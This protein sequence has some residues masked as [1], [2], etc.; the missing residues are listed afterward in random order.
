MKKCITLA[1]A[2]MMMVSAA[3]CGGSKNDGSAGYDVTSATALLEAVWANYP[4]DQKFPVMGGDY[5]NMVDGAPGTFDYT[6]AEYLDSLLAVPADGA[7]L[8]DDAASV[9]HA[10]MANHFTCGAFHVA[11]AANV[12][13]FVSLMQDSLANRQWLCG[14]PEKFV[15]IQDGGNYVVT[16]FGLAEVVD[17]FAAQ[18]TEMGGSIV[19]DEGIA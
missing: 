6:N 1:L 9:I 15:I 12:D 18:L 3:A 11:D 19:A 4:E 14:Q 13:T 7:A 10:M 16:L 8:V 5:D 17:G 2:V